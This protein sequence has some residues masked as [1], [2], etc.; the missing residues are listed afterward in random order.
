MTSKTRI[1]RSITKRDVAGYL[2]EN[3]RA[4]GVAEHEIENWASNRRIQCDAD[5]ML[6]GGDADFDSAECQEIRD[7][8]AGMVG[9]KPGALVWR[10]GCPGTPAQGRATGTVKYTTERRMGG[11]WVR[12]AVCDWRLPSGIVWQEGIACTELEPAL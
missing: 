3:A 1:N 12:F 9:C 5:Y 11:Q 6:A 7:I 10:V 4:G 8:I 2:I